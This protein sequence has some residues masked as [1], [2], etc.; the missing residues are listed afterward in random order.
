MVTRQ[1]ISQLETESVVA[2]KLEGASVIPGRPIDAKE[3][4]ARAH[5]AAERV[6]AENQD[7]PSLVSKIACDIASE[8]IESIRLPG[9]DLNS[10]ELAKQYETSRTPVREAL[11][12]LEKEGLVEIPPRRR[13]RVMSLS[14]KE[15]KEIY[16][17]RGSLLGILAAD[18]AMNAS[19]ES[20]DSLKPYLIGMKEACDRDDVLT[21]FWI[22]MDFHEKS[23]GL[24][25]NKTAK[26]IIDSLLLRTL[27]LRRLG[28]SK[29]GRLTRSL[30][31]HTWLM[32]AYEERDA[33]LAAAI[34]Y[35]NHMGGLAAVEGMYDEYARQ[36]SRQPRRALREPR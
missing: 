36:S 1:P 5:A 31:D 12:L 8:I 26:R 7:R 14:M 23:S 28:L 25:N 34:I 35:S 17:A 10:V 20:I 32:Q 4:F 21:Y 33:N 11:M 27:R 13:P 19:R 15:I 22:N 3:S 29:P 2:D 9:D 30:E 24:T 16:H 18:I 6:V